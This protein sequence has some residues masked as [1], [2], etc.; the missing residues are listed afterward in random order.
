MT[1][2]DETR[3]ARI[4]AEEVSKPGFPAEDFQDL[5]TEIGE[6]ASSTVNACMIAIA[7]FREAK[8]ALLFASGGKSRAIPKKEAVY[9]VYLR[10]QSDAP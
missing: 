2:V 10:Y 9:T 4:V 6:A 7:L 1:Q 5:L 8:D 3:L